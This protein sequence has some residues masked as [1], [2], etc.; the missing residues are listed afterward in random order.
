[1]R[2]RV[3][4]TV[5][6]SLF[7]DS[8]STHEHDIDLHAVTG[9]G[10]GAPLTRAKPG[11]TKR[12]KFKALKPGLY[13]YHC[14]A[15]DPPV[16][17]ANGMYGLILVERK[18]GLPEVDREFYL[19]QGELYTQGPM[20][21]KGF[22]SFSRIKMLEEKPDYVVFN[23]RTGALVDHPL[24][25]EVGETIRL[26]VGNAGVTKVSSLHLIGEIFDRVWPEASTTR[27]LENIQT[28]LIPAGGAAMIE[29]K[30][31]VPGSYTLVDHALARMD[32][33]AWGS[34][35]VTGSAKKNIYSGR[36]TSSEVLEKKR[37]S[38]GIQL[39]RTPP[40]GR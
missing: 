33:G 11:E 2:V 5:E 36:S 16:H 24:T 15:G 23:G 25:A 35:K 9:P 20:G 27:P 22:Q 30:V 21:A 19:V 29:F 34:L 28:T 37:A 3:G 13:I 38:G 17:I 18:G 32:R 12:F 4:D 40:S 26:F 7:N 39:I 8:T 6:L 10:G 31:E 14:A 1:M